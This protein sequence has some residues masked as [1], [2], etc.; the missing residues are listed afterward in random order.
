[1]YTNFPHFNF[2]TPLLVLEPEVHIP[3][4]L[5]GFEKAVCTNLS[6]IKEVITLTQSSSQI[7]Q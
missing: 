2:L 7:K 4:D 1:M 6:K 5:T 3:L